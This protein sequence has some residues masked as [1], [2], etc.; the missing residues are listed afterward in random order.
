[1]LSNL[2]YTLNYIDIFIKLCYNNFGDREK[3]DEKHG[4][5]QQRKYSFHSYKL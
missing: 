3:G 5:C 4:C 2:K 1:M